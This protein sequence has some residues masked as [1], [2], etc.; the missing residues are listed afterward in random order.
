[1]AKLNIDAIREDENIF[2]GIPRKFWCD[3]W[4]FPGTKDRIPD[5]HNCCFM[6]Y[7]G[8]P[9]RNGVQ[10]PIYE[11]QMRILKALIEHDYLCIIKSPKLGIT[12]LFLRWCIWKAC[13]DPTWNKGQV[14]IVVATGMQN[15]SIMITRFREILD[16]PFNKIPIDETKFDNK[17]SF[18]LNSVEFFAFPANNPEALRSKTNPKITILD[19]AAMFGLADDSIVKTAAEHYIGSID[20]YKIAMISTAGVEASGMMYDIIHGKDKKYHVIKLTDP[21]KYG[22][23]RHPVT[24]TSMYIESVLKELRKDPEYRRNHLGEWGYSKGG[25]FDP[26]DLDQITVRYMI[27]NIRACPGET[28]LAVDPAYG[29]GETKSGSEFAMVGAYV[30]DGK[31]YVESCMTQV[32]IGQKRARETIMTKM[33]TGGYDALCIDNSQPGLCDDM[34]ELGYNVYRMNFGVL[35][36]RGNM[37]EVIGDED[38]DK[39]LEGMRMIDVLERLVARGVVQIHPKF[40]HPLLQQLRGITKNDRGLPDKKKHAFDAGDAL[41]MAVWHLKD[42][43]G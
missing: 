3:N 9:W 36:R 19:E 5:G 27:P 6:H 21:S 39:Y 12:E 28:V 33:N 24:G 26:D 16:N 13:T 42:Y 14:M 22:L 20:H 8:M 1:M 2:I 41:E 17:R 25:I 40:D 37:I 15:T 23:P 30:K 4:Y 32:S 34:E 31:I 29:K 18:T 43:L 7:T 10:H 11:Y 35:Q 38:E